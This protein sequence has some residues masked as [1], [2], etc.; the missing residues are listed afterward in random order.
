MTADKCHRGLLVVVINGALE[1]LRAHGGAHGVHV[2]TRVLTPNSAL[3]ETPD[4]CADAE[5]VL[6]IPT[7]TQG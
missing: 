2:L 5:G 4:L 3:W 7:I 1:S 6:V